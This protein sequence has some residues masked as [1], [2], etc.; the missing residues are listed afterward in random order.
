M[1]TQNTG[2]LRI[3]LAVLLLSAATVLS[4]QEAP[5]LSV[6]ELLQIIDIDTGLRDIY[7]Q[8]AAGESIPTDRYYLLTGTVTSISTLD[9]DPAAFYSEVEFI[10]AEWSGNE[11]RSYKA[12]LVFLDGNFAPRLPQRAPRNPGP[13]VIRN[14]SEGMALSEFYD[15]LEL[16]NGEI[17]PVFIVSRFNTLD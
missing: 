12:L 3:G 6:E 8:I 16:P 2:V 5:S 9:P 10:S 13:E 11:I 4:A 1:K 14:N 15:I 7:E 17:L